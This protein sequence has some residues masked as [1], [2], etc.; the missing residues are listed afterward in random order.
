MDTMRRGCLWGALAAMA[1]GSGLWLGG[2]RA[3]RAAEPDVAGTSIAP[4]TPPPEASP[5]RSRLRANQDCAAPVEPADP[6]ESAK[7]I[8]IGNR[9]ATL[10]GYRLVFRDPESNGKLTLGV[11][12]PI[13]E[14]SGRNV[15]GL[16]KYLKFFVQEG[17][18][19]ILVTGDTGEVASAIARVLKV[20]A[21]SKLPILVVI[22]N[23]ECIADFK[24]GVAIAQ[25]EFSNIINLN[26]IRAVEFREATIVSLPGYYDP[27]YINCA[28]GCRYYKSTVDDLV[29][30][31]K[32]SPHPVVLVSHGPPRG[33]GS[34]SLDYAISGG[35]VGDA[36][37]N[38][39]IG[40]ANIAFG[41]FSNIKEAG[42]RATDLPGTTVIPAATPVKS[43]YLN[44]GPADTLNWPMNDGTQSHGMAAVLTIQGSEATWKAFRAKPITPDEQS[45]A[46]AM[47]VAA[48]KQAPTKGGK[49]ARP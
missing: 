38:R 43:L 14:D 46:K 34:Q 25:K 7:E 49:D 24:E 19:A 4:P 35:N 32:A 17:T 13:N 20:L 23:R 47:D 33:E 22:G 9:S 37:I 40:E 31:A 41:A 21:E 16:K 3:H 30:L 15:L 48:R 42:A 39:A 12:G 1:L 45:K 29:E 26:Q 36:E 28:T 2:C 27:N 18:D 10:A 11:L 5:A 8:K 6:G 44:P